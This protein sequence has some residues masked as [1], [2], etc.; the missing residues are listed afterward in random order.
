[1]KHD[2]CTGVQDKMTPPGWKTKAA[3]VKVMYMRGM[4]RSTSRTQALQC[5]LSSRDAL[6]W[7]ESMKDYICCHHPSTK[8]KIPSITYARSTILL[9]LSRLIGVRCS[10]RGP[11]HPLKPKPSLATPVD[12]AWTRLRPHSPPSHPSPHTCPSALLYLDTLPALSRSLPLCCTHTNHLIPLINITPTR[13]SSSHPLETPVPPT[14]DLR[15]AL[16]DGT[17]LAGSNQRH[18]H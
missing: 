8:P 9:H 4:W 10:S 6:G 12:E 5:M 16:Y 1:M 13:G 7:L 3:G 11:R 2:R 17:S 15:L 18:D 14:S